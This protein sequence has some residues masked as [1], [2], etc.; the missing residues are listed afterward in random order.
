MDISATEVKRLMDRQTE[1]EQ[2]IPLLQQELAD[3]TSTLESLKAGS[4]EPLLAQAS[5]Q[6][7]AM[8]NTTPAGVKGLL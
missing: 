5:T 7:E 2:Q 4:G 6:L 1:L 3:I 8:S